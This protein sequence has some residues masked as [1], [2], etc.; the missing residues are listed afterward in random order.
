MSQFADW[1]FAPVGWL[2]DWA[3]WADVGWAADAPSVAGLFLIS[4]M[5][6][7]LVSMCAAFAVY[8]VLRWLEVVAE[9][10]SRWAVR[11]G[12]VQ[13]LRR[14]AVRYVAVTSV[15]SALRG[16]TGVRMGSSRS[17]STNLDPWLTSRRTR[18]AVR[19]RRLLAAPVVVVRLAWFVL[20]WLGTPVGLYLALGSAWVLLQ[21][22]TALVSV[23]RWITG[24]W[25]QMATPS[26]VAIVAALLAAAA[27]GL[28]HGLT[29]R[30]RG[31]NTFL[32]ERAA[33]ATASLEQVRQVAIDLRDSV[34]RLVEDHV[35]LYPEIVTTAVEHATWDSFTVR[36]GQ[37]VRQGDATLRRFRWRRWPDW[38]QDRPLDRLSGSSGEV[39]LLSRHEEYLR[40]DIERMREAVGDRHRYLDLVRQAPA[41]VLG[42]L[43]ELAPSDARDHPSGSGEMEPHPVV[44]LLGVSRLDRLGRA[45]IRQIKAPGFDVLDGIPPAGMEEDSRVSRPVERSEPGTDV[46]RRR[47]HLERARQVVDR[48]AGL[49]MNGLWQATCFAAQMGRLTRAIERGHN[50]RSPLRGLVARLGQ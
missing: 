45:L 36:E 17:R 10:V 29:S 20:R 38:E 42:A 11:G 9:R 16:R 47:E 35:S 3:D 24:L 41:S 37:V 26:G 30:I 49:Y 31:R 8:E 34:N 33:T 46:E 19:V 4:S 1:V 40:N 32:R 27:V 12:D 28:D 14:E 23:G 44:S 39:E 18:A 21:P 15:L 22:E 43:A 2:A 6:L 7:L 13:G 5:V 48:Q 25:D 50:P